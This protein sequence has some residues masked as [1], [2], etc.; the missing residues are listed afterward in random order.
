MNKLKG[1]FNNS[2]DVLKKLETLEN[3]VEAKRSFKQAG[4]TDLFVK[5]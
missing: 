5:I 4:I 3:S 2:A 1:F